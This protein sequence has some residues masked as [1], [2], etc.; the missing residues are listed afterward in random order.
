[1]DNI[2]DRIVELR[3]LLEYHSKKY[4]VDDAPEI[5]DYEYDMLFRELEDLE[6]Q[7]PE[8]YDEHSP[9]RRVGGKA[10][11]KFEKVRHDVPMGSLT[12][13]FSFEELEA[14]LAKNGR[15]E[16]SVEPKIDGLSVSLV[17]ENG[18]LVRGATRGDGLVGENVTGNVRTINS[19]PLTIDY[20]G[21]LEVRG[22]VF[23]PKESF[24]KLN[25]GKEEGSGFANPRNAAAGSLRQL[26]PGITA[27]RK[28]DIFIFNVQKC[29]RSFSTHSETFEFLKGLGFKILPYVKLAC[30]PCDIESHISFIGDKRASLSFDID[31]AVVKINDLAL[32][33]ELGS[34]GGRP[35]W[36]VAYKY[37][38]EEKE[39]KLIDVAVQVGRTGVL[40][41]NAV[42]EPVKLAGTTVSR[43]T[44][45]NFNYIK[46][47]DIRIGDT[48]AVH[49]AGDIIP[50]IAFVNLSKRPS[51]AVA[52]KAP[53]FCPSCGEPVFADEEEAALRCTNAECPSQI[54]RNIE[55][56]ASKDAMNIDGMGPQIVKLLYERGLIR[57][58]ADIYY[59]KKED[60]AALDRMGEKS[61]QNLTDSIEASKNRGL[62]RLLYALGIRQIGEKA[63]ETLAEEF[64]DI[65]KFFELKTEDLV[66]LSDIGEISALY[67]VNFFSHPNTRKLVDRLKEAGVETLIK[68]EIAD[69]LY[70]EGLTFVLTGKLPTLSRSEAEA[71]IKKYGGKTSSSVSKT[72]D[73]LLCGDD[74]GS[75]LTKAEALGT[76]II[77]EQTFLNMV[78]EQK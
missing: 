13:V 15:A 27:S 75:K 22:E 25:E 5:S 1:M 7:H 18:K 19:I 62:A 74:A 66:S 73:Y 23:M 48:V 68:R 70:L 38:P 31:G 32:R 10:L 30:D 14:F 45:H 65:E 76:K 56:F 26:D 54:L 64:G 9:T 37:P 12:D 67:V 55:H 35:K 33:N 11:E 78:K 46:E 52:Y 2:R 28:L 39:T 29:D 77:D 20:T 71:I 43:A 59:L 42:L 51:D 57:G 60:L 61:A 58:I 21:H 4:Y 34:V 40:T 72:T 8:Y 50:E 49:K 16:Y 3:K 17:Y 36:A 44:L 41:P 63:A 6:N 53:E 69:A 24:Y 47:K